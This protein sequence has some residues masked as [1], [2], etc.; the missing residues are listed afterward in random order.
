MVASSIDRME[1]LMNSYDEKNM[2]FTAHERPMETPS[3]RY[4]CRLKNSILGRGST[5]WPREYMREFFW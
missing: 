5:F 2:A 1:F 3:P 4:M